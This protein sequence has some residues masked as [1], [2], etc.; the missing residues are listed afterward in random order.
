[1]KEAQ[2]FHTY[3]IRVIHILP[4]DHT[5]IGH[6]PALAGHQGETASHIPGER[7]LFASGSMGVL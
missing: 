2:K 7:Q 5:T 1:M 6:R 4:Q 3:S